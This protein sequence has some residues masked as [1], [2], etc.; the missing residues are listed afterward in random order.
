M[1]I[2]GYKVLDTFK[3]VDTKTGHEDT[4][5]ILQR[6][7]AYYYIEIDTGDEGRVGLILDKELVTGIVKCNLLGFVWLM[8]YKF[9]ESHIQ[10]ILRKAL[11]EIP[12]ES[13]KYHLAK[14]DLLLLKWY[15]YYAEIHSNPIGGEHPSF[16]ISS[17]SDDGILFSNGKMLT[18]SHVQDCCE[19]N[20]AD[21]CAVD[22]TVLDYQ[23][24]EPLVWELVEEYGFRF[25]N[26]GCM[27]GVPCFSE[28][29]GYY[30]DDVDIY[31]DGICVLNAKG[32][33]MG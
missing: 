26:E 24:H 19:F 30:S 5:Y 20:Y 28:Q 10:H 17:I 31:Y 6:K 8:D 18:C 7:P 3:F 4:V 23:L 22:D 21:F 1:K 16:V 15:D 11:L 25:G 29:D 14:C 33:L 12:M 32:V 13:F 2:M 9:D 27:I